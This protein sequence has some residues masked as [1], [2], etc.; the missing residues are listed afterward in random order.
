MILQGNDYNYFNGTIRYRNILSDRNS[1][2]IESQTVTEDGVITK[3]MIEH[4]IEIDT[5]M[6]VQS[7]FI[8]VYIFV[9]YNIPT[10]I[11]LFIYKD[12]RKKL[13]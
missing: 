9:L 10:V 7:I 13:R 3:Q 2:Y 1:C 8:A 4:P 12:G 6:K 11:L 5:S